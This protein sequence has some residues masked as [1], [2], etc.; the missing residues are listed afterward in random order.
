MGALPESVLASDWLRAQGCSWGPKGDKL[1]LQGAEPR[2]NSFL[3]GLHPKTPWWGLQV[4]F[5]SLIPNSG[6]DSRPP[7]P[8][9]LLQ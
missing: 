3:T 8:R 2:L 9:A 6:K 5:P 4:L 7:T 1:I